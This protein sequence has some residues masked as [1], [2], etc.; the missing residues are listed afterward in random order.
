MASGV[1]W[2]PQM[3]VLDINSFRARLRPGIAEAGFA[4]CAGL[5]FLLVFK[6]A[7]RD[8]PAAAYAA[9][10][11]GVITLSHAR[12]LVDYGFVGINPSGERIEGFSAPLQFLV[13]A[14]VYGFTH[15]GYA[16]FLAAQTVLST[17]LLG[18][19]F[20]RLL[21]AAGADQMVA[22][23]GAVIGAGVLGSCGAFL[24]W[25]HSGMENALMNCAVVWLLALLVEAC[26]QGRPSA[27]LPLVAFAAS[28]ARIDAVFF[29]AP[30]MFLAVLLGPRTLL[31]RGVAWAAAWIAFFSL[32]AW[33]FGALQPNTA[34]A[35]Q[36]DVTANLV[37][38]LTGERLPDTLAAFDQVVARNPLWLAMLAAPLLVVVRRERPVLVGVGLCFLL[39]LLCL[40]HPM[41]F[42]KARLDPARLTS[43]LAPVC[44]GLMLIVAVR[45]RLPAPVGLAIAATTLVPPLRAFLPGQLYEICC[46]S[47]A[48]EGVRAWATRVAAEHHIVRP[49]LATPDLGAVS[50]SKELNVLDL[51]SLGSDVMSRVSDS[52]ILREWFFELA[53]PDLVEVHDYWWIKNSFLFND[54]RFRQRYAVLDEHASPWFAQNA[55]LF[56]DGRSGRYLRRELMRDSTGPERRLHDA[57]AAS[58]SVE[59]LANELRT[60]DRGGAPACLYVLRTAYRFLPELSGRQGELEALFASAS[61]ARF[62]NWAMAV[63]RAR[64]D[65]RL[66]R[67]VIAWSAGAHHGS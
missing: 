20:F 54:P 29:V 67:A 41:L 8:V 12:N 4:I 7:L 55:P 1:R 24:L 16:T 43:F 36:I 35:Q 5:A 51:G 65:G 44:V 48:F 19:G 50:F 53:A 45:T 40:A 21:R 14:M 49:L 23:V 2:C 64:R 52:R 57:M 62:R 42:G 17:L 18:A 47:E 27:A 56:Q 6:M 58:P 34:V 32:R 61:D 66:S 28:I 59:T 26:A 11:D 31:P 33:Y 25:H 15:V 30:L 10:D 63:L 9:R 38:W 46:S 22:L 37:S 3:P 13:F 60:C 39:I